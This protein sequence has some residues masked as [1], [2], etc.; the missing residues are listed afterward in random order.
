M[1]MTDTPV[2]VAISTKSTSLGAMAKLIELHFKNNLHN[3]SFLRISECKDY[4]KSIRN[5]IEEDWDDILSEYDLLEKD[6]IFWN[7]EKRSYD[8]EVKLRKLKSD[9]PNHSFEFNTLVIFLKS[10][11]KGRKK[12][13]KNIGVKKDSK[14][15]TVKQI[16]K[17]SL[18]VDDAR[19]SNIGNLGGQ[20]TVNNQTNIQA[21]ELEIGEE[22][23]INISKPQYI[24]NQDPN[25]IKAPKMEIQPPHVPKIEKNKTPNFE[26]FIK[27]KLKKKRMSTE[28]LVKFD[29]FRKE[30]DDIE[31]SYTISIEESTTEKIVRGEFGIDENSNLEFFNSDLSKIKFDVIKKYDV[32]KKV[33]VASNNWVKNEKKRKRNDKNKDPNDKPSKI[34]KIEESVIKKEN[35]DGK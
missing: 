23:N 19:G 2:K 24:V 1:E 17:Q 32:I 21:E 8:M 31:D 27:N 4:N 18:N 34:R 26:N 6:G 14:K 20:N 29:V 25:S 22:N 5:I 15:E 13:G 12:K 35:K 3:I 9:F 11:S 30:D 33:I 7:G 16:E 28:K 10:K